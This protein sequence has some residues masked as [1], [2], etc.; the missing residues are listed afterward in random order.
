MQFGSYSYLWDL[1]PSNEENK[2]TIVN[3]IINRHRIILRML[4]TPT[5]SLRQSK[6]MSSIL[7]GPIPDIL[8]KP[9][10]NN[11]NQKVIGWQANQSYPTDII[12]DTPFEAILSINWT[13]GRLFVLENWKR[14]ITHSNFL[15]QSSYENVFG[16]KIENRENI[17][18]KYFN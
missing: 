16:F 8:S 2:Q 1:N 7:L 10:I 6:C 18:S 13:Q 5:L 12:N 15:L 14:I 17:L 4:K 3:T 9:V 11:D